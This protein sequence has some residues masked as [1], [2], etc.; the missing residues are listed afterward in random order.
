MMAGSMV[1]TRVRSPAT[2]R[3]TTLQ[4]SR[5]PIEGSARIAAWA[6]GGRHAPRITWGAM[7]A[8]IF[9]FSVACMS[10]SVSTPKP[11]AAS[12]SRVARTTSANGRSTMTAIA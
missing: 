8:P 6:K 2:L 9:A 7:S 4:G 5:S 11:W 3:T 10:I 1:S 12:A